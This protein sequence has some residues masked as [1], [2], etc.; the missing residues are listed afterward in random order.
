MPLQIL[1]QTL[2]HS[3][4]IL[5]VSSA[6]IMSA[7]ASNFNA[8]Q[9]SANKGN[10]EAQ[11]TLAT[12]YSNGEG[13]PQSYTK[14]IEWYTKAANQGEATAKHELG[15]MYANGE[16]VTPNYKKAIE[17]FQSAADQS[18]AF[19]KLKQF[20]NS[21]FQDYIK[22]F[23]QYEKAAKK[24]DADAQYAL[25]QVHSYNKD[26]RLALEWY[27]KA[28][29]QKHPHAREAIG[30]MYSN[31]LGVRQDH[32]KAFEWYEKAMIEGSANAYYRLGDRY[33]SGIGVPQDYSKA[34]MNYRHAYP[35]AKGLTPRYER[36]SRTS[37]GSN[38]DYDRYVRKEMYG[39]TCD[40]GNQNA[41]DSY[42]A[43]NEEQHNWKGNRSR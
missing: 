1:R 11:H 36:M 26:Y 14:A 31:G 17:W 27:K 6:L 40:D 35:Q 33:N 10:A 21:D 38:N 12:M 3:T 28:A 2:I 32:I 13:V 37:G 18:Y 4:M 34:V 24:G 41:C 29:D 15:E 42:R 19:L 39:K 9:T 30:D 7:T 43:I 5:A 8:I 16:G 25:G 22:N 20:N 23:E